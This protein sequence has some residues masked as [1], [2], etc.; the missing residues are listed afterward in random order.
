MRSRMISSSSKGG[1]RFQK[2]AD[3]GLAGTCLAHKSREATISLRPC[4]AV[5][6]KPPDQ[7]GTG[8]PFSAVP[9][10][11]A[12]PEGTCPEFRQRTHASDISLGR[13]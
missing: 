2:N 5:E 10:R 11:V 4:I 8:L 6:M 9:G 13:R 3:R 7:L 1:V 12:A